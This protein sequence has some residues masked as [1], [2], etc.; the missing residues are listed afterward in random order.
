[1]DLESEVRFLMGSEGPVGLMARRGIGVSDGTRSS[2]GLRL[3]FGESW[4]RSIAKDLATAKALV[5]IYSPNYFARSRPNY[6]ARE[7]FT[8]IKSRHHQIDVEKG[9]RII[10]GVNNVIPVLWCSE[11]ELGALG[12]PPPALRYINY[13]LDSFSK[14]LQDRYFHD[15][16]LRQ[17]RIRG[18][19]YRE[20]VTAI[21]RSIR[22]CL[23]SKDESD[24]T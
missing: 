20:L 4:E 21:A 1:M 16:M 2:L 8:F 12:L 24:A 19:P 7:F 9:E 10:R 22:S 6:C 18:N 5:C 14:K 13:N 11:Q 3:S 17:V 23:N 15:G